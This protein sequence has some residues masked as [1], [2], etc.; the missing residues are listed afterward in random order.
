MNQLNYHHLYYFYVTAKTGSIARASEELH[1]SPQTISGQIGV[2]E[3]YLDLKLFDRIG[4][5][6]QLND[7]GQMVFSYAED[8]FT[9]GNELI[10]G[11]RN[12]HFF[13]QNIVKVGVTDVIPKVLAFDIFRSVMDTDIPTNLVMKEGELSDL[14]SELAIGKLDLILSDQP[15]TPS[16]NV[17]AFSY[18]L[19]ESG[20]SFFAI[21]SLAEKLKASFPHSLHMQPFLSPGTQS[22]V[23]LGL[24][25]WFERLNIAPNIV[26][27]FDDSALKKL[28]AQ[29]GYGIFCAP[30]SVEAHV[31]KQYD[32]ELLGRTDDVK[33]R[34]YLI[35]PNRKLK[36]PALEPVL[37]AA[38]TV[39]AESRA[40]S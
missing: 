12:K 40:L 16:S 13:E 11:L 2:L 23:K 28:F 26:G 39:F 32:V 38:E 36:H 15:L 10:H 20:L 34:F 19:G 3:D 14:L 5:K 22:N 30:T 29:A 17:K 7:Q 27:E 18:L 8:I 24:L 1:L 37:A 31:K 6:L 25:T 4:R 9:L 35:S 33:E 21:A